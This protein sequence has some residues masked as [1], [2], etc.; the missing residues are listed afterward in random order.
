MPKKDDYDVHDLIFWGGLIGGAV[1]SY[2]LLGQ[3]EM[4]RL[5]QALLCL[6]IGAAIG[7]TAD[8]IYT[9]ARGT[10][11]SPNGGQQEHDRDA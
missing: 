10:P 8:R 4:H 2:Q 7:W 3:F 9:T 1:I 11:K 5:L 6:G